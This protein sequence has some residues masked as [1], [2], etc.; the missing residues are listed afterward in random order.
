MT[1]ERFN[2]LKTENESMRGLLDKKSGEMIELQRQLQEVQF[3]T[4]NDEVQIGE[5]KHLVF[6]MQ[7]KWEGMEEKLLD[8]TS[9]SKSGILG[10]LRCVKRFLQFF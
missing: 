8:P 1:K 3:K 2:E 4:S 5:L 7:F 9:K 6:T 10:K